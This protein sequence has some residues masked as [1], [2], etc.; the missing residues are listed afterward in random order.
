[1]LYET[2]YLVLADETTVVLDTLVAALGQ[3]YADVFD[4]P[5]DDEILRGM[6]RIES[7]TNIPNG[8]AGAG[9]KLHRVTLFADTAE[10]LAPVFAGFAS[11]LAKIAGD[12]KNGIRHTL[13][14]QDVVAR[15][16]HRKLAEEIYEIEMALREV[17]SFIFLHAYTDEPHTFLARTAL[18]TTP[19]DEPPRPEDLQQRHE[20]QLF[21]ILFNEYLALN[22][23]AETK[24][25]NLLELIREKDSF[26]GLREALDHLPI[27][28]D[29][30]AGFIAGLQELLE[31][32]ERVRNC[33]AHHRTI[34]KR[35]LDNYPQARA[36]LHRAIKE[37]WDKAK[38]DPVA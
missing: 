14:F 15:A 4:D 12:G 22:T 31:P 19:K 6:F 20:N 21:H 1:M 3:A 10:D 11:E 38:Q 34:P 23:P 26:E 37:F 17:L 16:E 7:V 2:R 30:H 9:L 28:N 35:T 5:P 36:D 33:V 8:K 24:L 25:T 18:K 27:R 29:D 32:V 13:K